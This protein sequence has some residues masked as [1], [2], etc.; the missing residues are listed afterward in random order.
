VEPTKDALFLFKLHGP[1]MSM[2]LKGLPIL[3]LLSL[4]AVPQAISQ[5]YELK[6]YGTDSIPW[7]ATD[8]RKLQEILNER[9]L[10]TDLKSAVPLTYSENLLERLDN[11]N[12]AHQI[13]SEFLGAKK[14]SET[15]SAQKYDFLKSYSDSKDKGYNPKNVVEAKYSERIRE[16][17]DEVSFIKHL[18]HT[19][20]D[21]NFI[22]RAKSLINE[23]K[24]PQLNGLLKEVILGEINNRTKERSAFR[25]NS[26]NWDT[27][28]EYTP[29]ENTKPTKY[30]FTTY[31]LVPYPEL[32]ELLK[33]LYAPKPQTRRNPPS[34]DPAM[35]HQNL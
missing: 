25:L 7:L 20:V 31:T 4:W 11:R 29:Q 12:L 8:E 26:L 2:S 6:G 1:I 24:N 33:Q 34:R 10:A 15:E 9:N 22:E 16:K 35:D 13:A 5:E 18:D 17:F 30:N 27:I 3:L 19:A 21:K 28:T 23:I 32:R 14:L